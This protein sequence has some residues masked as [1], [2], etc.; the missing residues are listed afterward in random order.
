MNGKKF[1]LPYVNDLQR[2]DK[3]IGFQIRQAINQVLASGW[4]VLGKELKSFEKEFAKYLKVKYVI[5]VNSG[6]DALF[7]ALKAAEINQ[8]DEVITVANTFISTVLAISHVGAKPI[9]VEIDE[10]TYNID[11]DKIEKK[12][13]SKTRA[14]IPVHLYGYPCQMDRI[15]T[16]AKKYH[17]KII[18]DACQAHGSSFKGKKLGTIGNIGCFSFY[19]PKNLGAYGDG[20]ALVTNDEQ[21]ANR[22]YLLRN[23]GE[24]KK[25]HYQIKGFNSRLD[26]IQATI[27]RTKLRHL[28]RWNQKRAALSARYHK[29]L[30]GWPI[31]LPPEDTPDYQGN[32]YA[33]VI[34]IKRRDALQKF[35]LENRIGIIIHYPVPIHRQQSCPELL[36]QGKDLKV[37]EKIAQEI[38][39]LPMFPQLTTREVDYVCQKIKEFFKK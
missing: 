20:G 16:L 19:P 9:L 24:V 6:T 8:D 36:V 22:A 34:R 37:T 15:Q 27:L 14:I 10:K 5:G 25:Y 7:L 21:I 39:S 38:L 29:N 35:L 1:N 4:F 28:D 31:I 13:T 11:Q 18:E 12:I 26:E 17:L 33:F 30:V 32:H 23:Y 2:E 3:E